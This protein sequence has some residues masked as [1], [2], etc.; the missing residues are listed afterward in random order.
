MRKAR[1]HAVRAQGA[2]T[3]L[4]MVMSM[5]V[6]AVILGAVGSAML[7]SA[8]ILPRDGDA[9]DG[10]IRAREAARRIA[11][12]LSIATLIIEASDKTVTFDVPDRDSNGVPERIGFSWSGTPGDPIM[13][14]MNGQTS[15]LEEGVRKLELAYRREMRSTESA[16]TAAESGTNELLSSWSGPTV[17]Q[18][19]IRSTL[20]PSVSVTPRGTGGATHYRVTSV[21]LFLGRASAIDSTVGVQL[22][23][24]TATG[25]PG[26][27]I[28]ASATILE[29]ALPA[30]PGWVT[31]AFTGTTP[32]PIDTATWIVLRRAA[33]SDAAV[34]P[35]ATAVAHSRVAYA[36]GSTVTTDNCLPFQLHG[37]VT[38]PTIVTTSST[39][40]LGVQ[41]AVQLG[42]SEVATGLAGARLI[43]APNLAGTVAESQSGDIELIEEVIETV[44][45]I[46]GGIVGGLG[47][48]LGGRR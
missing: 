5:A 20:Q 43:N 48:L 13:M 14:T 2:F 1:P 21:R 37:R 9:L 25:A 19:L 30:S 32:T 22:K 28:L 36:M 27:T 12:E 3:L 47:G 44:D 31:V 39:H 40:A 46:V 18:V 7:I 24:P 34:A 45:D 42:T 11:D 35:L 4:E 29:S 41:V 33:G 15:I 8:K 16:G 10:A 26:S 6:L 23:N 38:R 17:S